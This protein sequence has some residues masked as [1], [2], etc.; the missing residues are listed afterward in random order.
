MLHQHTEPKTL[1]L[2]PPPGAGT[3]IHS[4][5]LGVR[6]TRSHLPLPTV[7][8]PPPPSLGLFSEHPP[9]SQH[10]FLN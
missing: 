4:D 6:F 1:P 7:N 10:H 5:R 2:P 9:S 3:D 8:L